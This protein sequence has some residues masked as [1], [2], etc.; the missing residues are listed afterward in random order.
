MCIQMEMYILSKKTNNG[1]VAEP[2]WVC[3]YVSLNV[4]HPPRRLYNMAAIFRYCFVYIA[5]YVCKIIA[6]VN[7]QD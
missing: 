3:A 2:R 4:L 6:F 5:L 7:F 1:N